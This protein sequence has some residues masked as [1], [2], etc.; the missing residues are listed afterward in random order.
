[1]AP[2]MSTPRHPTPWAC[3]EATTGVPRALET[4][5]C[6]CVSERGHSAG[7]GDKDVRVCLCLA[8]FCRCQ[9]I[10]MMYVCVY[11][12]VHACVQGARRLPTPHEAFP[13]PVRPLPQG[14]TVRHP[15]LEA[16]IRVVLPLSAT[17]DRQAGHGQQGGQPK[18]SAM[19]PGSERLHCSLG[20]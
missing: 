4:T 8:C 17:L 5:W 13:H 16:R 2:C 9:R 12:C 19:G 7:D 6:V 18:V 10:C 14:L 1:M 11:V 15:I 3:V 20:E